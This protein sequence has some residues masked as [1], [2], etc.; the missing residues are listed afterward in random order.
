MTGAGGEKEEEETKRREKPASAWYPHQVVSYM[1]DKMSQGKFYI[2]CPDNDV[3]EEIDRKRILWAV[4][5]LME[6]REALS[7]WREGRK[8]EFEA[9]MRG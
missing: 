9:F 6:G 4:G 7:R 3:S 1:Y 5:D 8:A 2:I